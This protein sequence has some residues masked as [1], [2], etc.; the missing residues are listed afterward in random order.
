MANNIY[1]QGVPA[2]TG[3]PTAGSLG[4]QGVAATA[5]SYQNIYGPN[6]VPATTGKATYLGANGANGTTVT[7]APAKNTPQS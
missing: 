6:G 4:T 7:K 3:V 5:A 2:A 1:K